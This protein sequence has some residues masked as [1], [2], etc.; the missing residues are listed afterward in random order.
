VTTDGRKHARDART[1]TLDSGKPAGALGDR[2]VDI[3]AYGN[4]MQ[5]A[6][7]DSLRLEITTW[8]AVHLAQPRSFGH[9]PLEGVAHGARAATV[10]L[11]GVRVSTAADGI[12]AQPRPARIRH[13]AHLLHL[14]E[15]GREAG[16]GQCFALRV[17]L[18]KA[19]RAA[20]C[21]PPASGRQVPMSVAGGL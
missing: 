19:R 13:P 10:P 21:I 8:T 16:Q 2:K 6:S 5:V 12:A 7:E 20:S 18:A 14:E 15:E 17:R 1:A 3:L 11:S 4:L 9:Q